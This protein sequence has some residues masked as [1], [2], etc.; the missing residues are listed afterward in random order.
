MTSLATTAKGSDPVEHEQSEV[1]EQIKM[2]ARARKLHTARR[3]AERIHTAAGLP[4]VP[5]RLVKTTICSRA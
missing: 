5:M 2:V 1:I 4:S 3:L